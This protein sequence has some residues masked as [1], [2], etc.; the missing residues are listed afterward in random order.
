MED[1]ELQHLNMRKRQGGSR[2]FQESVNR[3]MSEN[4]V[5]CCRSQE[6]NVFPEG[7]NE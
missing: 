2:D 1:E 3:D 5:E 6:K 7:N 4:E